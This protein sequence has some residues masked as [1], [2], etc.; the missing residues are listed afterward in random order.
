[1]ETF[2]RKLKAKAYQSR[3]VAIV[4]NGS[5]APTAAKCM[6][7]ILEEMKNIQICG[8]TVTIKS[9]VKPETLK[10]FDVMLDELLA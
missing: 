1:M 8:Q 4:E 9:A 7:A 5:W 2:L 3:R 10:A 6:R